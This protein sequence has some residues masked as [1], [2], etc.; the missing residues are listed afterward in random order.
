MRVRGP[1]LDLV[2]VEVQVLQVGAEVGHHTELVMGQMQVQQAADVEHHLGDALVIQLVVVEPDEGQVCEVLEVALG[3]VL[4]VVPVEKELEDV[5]GHVAGHLP[6]DVVC[7][8]E[9]HEVLQVLEDVLAQVAV[10]DAVVVEVQ[11]HQVLH[12]VEGAGRD[13]GDLIAAEAELLQLLGQVVG[14]LLQLVPLHVEVEEVGDLLEHLAVDLADAVVGQVHP[15][16]LGG[17]FEGL[18]GNLGG[19]GT[20]G[21]EVV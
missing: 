8:V 7:Q 15:L 1:T 11:Q 3:D 20:G 13:L 9:L 21:R 6:Q 14:D 5:G 17:V 19:S 18:G 12:L 4:N 10:A 2:V 16:Q